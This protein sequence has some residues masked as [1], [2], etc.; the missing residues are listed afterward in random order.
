MPK[1][2]HVSLAHN[3]LSSL[4]E[5]M[6]ANR[7]PGKYQD[8]EIDLS[9]NRLR[10]IEPGTFRN[11]TILLLNLEMNMFD[12]LDDVQLLNTTTVRTLE[13]LS[14]ELLSASDFSIC[15]SKPYFSR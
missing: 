7:A 14:N 8:M 2:M 1:L 15:F 11:S 10:K 3:N 13:I 5:G 6:F 4:G 12:K 9:Y